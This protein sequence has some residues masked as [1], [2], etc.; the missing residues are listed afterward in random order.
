MEGIALNMRIVLDELRA[1]CPV[2]EEMVAV[3]GSSRSAFWRNMFADALN[4]RIVKT[5]I[6]QQAGSLGAAAIAAVGAGLW[7]DFSRI[8]SIHH[9]N[10][11]AEPVDENGTV[12]EILLP[13]FR[14]AAEAQAMLGDALHASRE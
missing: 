1:L 12:Y 11:I 13:V 10:D 7:R 4:I 5:N 14:Q 6:G 9:V 2:A 3:G 8:D